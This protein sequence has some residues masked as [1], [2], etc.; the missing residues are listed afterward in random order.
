MNH[1]YR[2]VIPPSIIAIVVGAVVGYAS[3]RFWYGQDHPNNAQVK[4]PVEVRDN[5][6]QYQFINPLLYI[7]TDKNLYVDQYKS[8]VASVNA[9][10][11]TAVSSGKIAHAS[12]YFRDMNTG[13]WTGIGEDELYRPSSMIKVVTLMATMKS[14]EDETVS[15][16]DTLSYTPTDPGLQYYPSNDG[17]VTSSYSVQDLFKSMIMYSDNGSDLALLSNDGIKNE[18]IS[19]YNAFRLPLASSS[20]EDF[21]SARSYSVIWR[22]LYNSTLLSDSDSNQALRLLS[23]SSFKDGLVAG[24]P[25]GV[26]VAHKFGEFTDDAPSGVVI[27]RELHDCGIVY[28]PGHPYLLCVMTRGADFPSLAQTIAGVSKTVY[29]YVSSSTPTQ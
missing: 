19:L 14:V 20:D 8:L 17:M 5:I 11:N 3:D 24:V 26:T 15:L 18:Y 29:D 1:L 2:V 16:S 28:Y 22:T 12:V 23:M 6:A 10:I 27:N 4:A 9:H 7:G 25:A 13:H 21:M